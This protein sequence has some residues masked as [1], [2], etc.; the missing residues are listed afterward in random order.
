MDCKDYINNEGEENCTPS[1][2]NGKDFD[3]TFNWKACNENDRTI[4]IQV[5]QSNIKFQK[6]KL[7]KVNDTLDAGE[8][9][10]FSK[11]ISLNTCD[12]NNYF[13]INVQ[14]SEYIKKSISKYPF[15]DR[16]CHSYAFCK[17]EPFVEY[18][19]APSHSM[20]PSALP[21]ISLA[22]TVTQ[23]PSISQTPSETP[24]I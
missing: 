11:I 18:T 14:G 21:S 24:S 2:E 15:R 22:P 13:Q 19:S 8:C 5:K 10:E 6:E 3:A 17:L 12:T 9:Q 4:K 16:S 20:I 7:F 1:E 23:A